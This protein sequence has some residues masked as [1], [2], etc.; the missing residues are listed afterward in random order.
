MNMQI[1]ARDFD[2]PDGVTE[3]VRVA[4]A[5][6]TEDLTARARTLRDAAFGNRLTYSRKVFL[7][8]TQLCRDACGY[9]TFAM[10]PANVGAPFMTI[11]EVLHVARE[12]KVLGCHEALFTL[13]ERPELRY[14]VA[15]R[16]LE[17]RGYESTIHYVAAAAC[18]VLSETGLLPHI[19]AGTL[20]DEEIALLRPVCASMGIMLESASERLMGHG[21]P[22]EGC[23]DKAPEARLSTLR[24]LG[25]ARVPTTTG[26]LV[27]IGETEDER[28]AALVAL[29]DLHRRY[30]HIQEIIIQNFR[31]K[32]GTRMAQ[33]PEP[34]LDELLRA[35]ALARLI[36][37]GDVSIQ[38]PPNLNPQHLCALVDAGI[39]DWGGISPVTSDFVNPEAPWPNIDALAG[40]MAQIG[41]TLAPRL[42]VY[43]G[44]AGEPSAWLD[45]GVATPVL[46]VS[47]A[48]GLARDCDWRSGSS[49]QPPAAII[50]AVF[51]ETRAEPSFEVAR[52]VDKASEGS[53]LTT[54]ELE[55]LFRVR[56]ADFSYVCQTADRLRRETVG[57]CVTYIVVRN[58]N[59]TNVCTYGCGFCAFSKGR[60]HE[61]LRGAPYTVSLEE[62]ARRTTE[63]WDRGATEVC[64]Q[65]GVHPTYTG[66]TYLDILKATKN[67]CPSMH[68][69][70][71]SPLEV[72]QGART[73]GLPVAEYLRMLKAEGLGSLPGTAAEILDDEV[74]RILCP[75]KLSTEEWLSIV[76]TAHSVG[77]RTT[78]TVMYGHVESP[79]HWARHIQLLRALQDRTGGFTE[80]VPLPFVAQEAPLFLKGRARPGPTFREAVLMHAVARIGFHTAI[81]NIQTSWVKLGAAGVAVCLAAGANDL[82]GTLM[83]ELITRSAGATHGQEACPKTMEN[84]IRQAGRHPQQRTTLYHP[85]GPDRRAA[86]LVANPLQPVQN[87]PIRHRRR[88]PD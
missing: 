53:P 15:A 17:V 4:A 56:G 88:R 27:G 5:A 8:L 54:Q 32:P 69:H 58:I 1:V 75:G 52:I 67:A 2:Q 36:F 24:R 19:N 28:I 63:A 65:G 23:P 45:R 44:F 41:H 70:A 16:W 82:G 13:G 18:A 33:S 38:V 7:P 48:E 62:I 10:A 20:S 26:L 25:E 40:Q 80:F 55:R 86:S 87:D 74:R 49:G 78:A 37:R 79:Y 11:D 34:P 50:S 47:D 84:W 42:T 12:G 35:V 3:W 29:R 31:A 71:F 81:P 72:A 30:G 59:Y 60:T 39:D 73:L 68:V 83:N 76:E 43:P 85:A 61:A 77:L 21:M 51:S 57:D 9:C 64:M 14:G 6:T 66:Q 46:H 22:H